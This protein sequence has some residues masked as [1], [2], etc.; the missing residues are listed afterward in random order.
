MVECKCSVTSLQA[1]QTLCLL[2]LLRVGRSV[3]VGTEGTCSC[4]RVVWDG[5]LVER[6]GSG[7]ILWC[8]H[9]QPNKQGLLD[10]C[11]SS[12]LGG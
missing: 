11:A 4:F 9:N 8:V 10:G 12:T 5:C 1:S 6:I 3:A 7:S 2:G